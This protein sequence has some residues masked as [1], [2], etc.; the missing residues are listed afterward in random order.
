MNVVEQYARAQLVADADAPQS[1]GRTV[2]VRLSYDPGRDPR[3]VRV[4]L[5]GPAGHEWSLRRELLERGLRAPAGSGDVQVWPCGRVQVV[6]EFHSAQGVFMVQFE[7]K[8]LTR[9]LRRAHVA[10]AAA[11]PVPH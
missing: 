8:A 5:S 1:V 7:T 9:F 6:V 4:T 2:P 3:A 10:A 11:E